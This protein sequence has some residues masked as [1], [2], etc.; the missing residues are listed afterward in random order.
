MRINKFLTPPK[1]EPKSVT[2]AKCSLYIP[3]IIIGS[4]TTCFCLG[5]RRLKE[6]SLRQLTVYAF[7]ALNPA[8][9]L[10]TIALTIAV[11]GLRFLG[12]NFQ[13]SAEKMNVLLLTSIVMNAGI[14]TLIHECGHAALASLIYR[15]AS[16]RIQIMPFQGGLTSFNLSYGL[17]PF[18]RFI[19]NN[20]ANTLISAGGFIASCLFAQ[21]A[22]TVTSQTLLPMKWRERIE[23]SAI[24]QLFFEFVYGMK[25]L[26]SQRHRIENDFTRLWVFEGLHPLIPI[27][28]TVVIAA[29]VILS[30]KDQPITE[31][32]LQ[33]QP[34][35][36]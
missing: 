23:A 35:S 25:A 34:L 2:S 8:I 33:L 3:S 18:G 10:L 14:S 7:S 28:I 19:G 20:L 6:L 21:A 12:H 31:A 4:A 17:T 36:K 5:T 32:Q 11:I 15:G 9:P 16:P 26:L 24:S 13:S 30:K 29:Q 27:A 22:K 1:I